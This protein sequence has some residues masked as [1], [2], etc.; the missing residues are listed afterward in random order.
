MNFHQNSISMDVAC[1]LT[2]I[3]LHWFSRIDRNFRVAVAFLW[4]GETHC[5]NGWECWRYDQF[6]PW[7]RPQ[8]GKIRISPKAVF[9]KPGSFGLKSGLKSEI[10]LMKKSGF[11]LHAD[12]TNESW[13]PGYYFKSAHD[14]RP[15]EWHQSNEICIPGFMK[16]WEMTP[17]SLMSA[18]YLVFV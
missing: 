4:R 16:P 15:I 11:F 14:V 1:V 8:Q 2:S 7:P 12:A 6:P 13:K 10:L 17:L 9:E 18:R 3:S 5:G